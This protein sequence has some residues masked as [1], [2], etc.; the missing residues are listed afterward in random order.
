MRG[1]LLGMPFPGSLEESHSLSTLLPPPFHQA[2]HP[3]GQKWVQGSHSPWHSLPRG[4]MLVA[5]PQTTGSGLF[6][7]TL[8]CFLK[9]ALVS[10]FENQILCFKIPGC[11]GVSVNSICQELA[12]AE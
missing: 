5:R 6:Y 12:G 9:I 10:T 8:Q 3:I 7:L 2:I 11:G 4:Q 1:T